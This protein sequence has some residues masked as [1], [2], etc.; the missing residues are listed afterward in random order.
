MAPAH[1]WGLLAVFG[2]LWPGWGHGSGHREGW[3]V[4]GARAGA[5]AELEGR[6]AG[7]FRDPPALD[8]QRAR[9]NSEAVVND[10]SLRRGDIVSTVK[11]LF[12]FIGRDESERT[13]DDFVPLPG[14]PR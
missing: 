11:G 8:L 14:S 10:S 12:V 9:R 4:A 6:G 1:F 3:E 13:A 5:R 2:L 7:G